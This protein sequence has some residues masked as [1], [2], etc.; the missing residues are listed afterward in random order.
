MSHMRKA[1]SS[2]QHSED[3]VI[4]HFTSGSVI[5][6]TALVHIQTK[7]ALDWGSPC[8]LSILR[9]ANVAC[10][11]RLCMPMSHVE[12]K[13]WLCPMS[14]YLLPPSLMSLGPMSHVEFKKRMCRPVYLRGPR[15]IQIHTHTCTHTRAH[16][17][18]HTHTHAHAHAHTHTLIMYIHIYIR[19]WQKM[20]TFLPSTS[21]LSY[22]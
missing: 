2:C 22:S 21:T 3:K 6:P 5:V 7:G 1:F 9:N 8:R 14:L 4:S 16:T 10:L 15:A 17:Y 20:H 18:T 12:F 13:K 11:C 19:V